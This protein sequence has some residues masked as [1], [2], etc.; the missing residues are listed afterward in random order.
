MLDTFIRDHVN[1][2]NVAELAAGLGL[3]AG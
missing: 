3:D 1:P 2:T